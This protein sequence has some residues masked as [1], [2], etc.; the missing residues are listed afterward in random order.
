MTAEEESQREARWRRIAEALDAAFEAGDSPEAELRRLLADDPRALELALQALDEPESDRGSVSGLAPGLLDE[1]GTS[2]DAEEDAS[3]HGRRLGAYRIL[4]P[5]GRGGMG[6]V[7][8]AERA[9]GQF[10][11]R[12][13]IKVLPWSAR[14]EA[15]LDRFAEERRILAGL[16]HSGI[17]HLLDG[18]VAEDGSPYL[19]LEYV[20]G[21][22]IDRY[23]RDN[24]LGLRA[25]LDLFLAVCDAVR[26]AHRNLVVHRDLKP[27]NILVSETGSVKLLDF[28]IA[29]LI[30]TEG[31]DGETRGLHFL[32]PEYAAPEQL[33]GGAVTT[34]TDVYALGVLLF[35]LLSGRVPLQVSGEPIAGV[36]ETVCR[37]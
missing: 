4:R 29:K 9:D 15:M 32:T 18:G 36:V 10:E 24:R 14:G 21:L 26:Y 5:L 27:G 34:A 3:W 19:V 13:A 2:L 1:L 22:P 17:A 8:L 37:T 20:A 6:A 16:E 7:F 31:D 33:S 30:D 11:R 28:G 35:R 25:R 23:C 12:V